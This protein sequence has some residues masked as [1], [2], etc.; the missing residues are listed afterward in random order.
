[1]IIAILADPIRH[2]TWDI[3]SGVLPIASWVLVFLA[4]CGC[5]WLSLQEHARS[6]RPSDLIVAYL[7]ASALC[8]AI[9]VT[10]PPLRGKPLLPSVQLVVKV[11]LLCLECQ[12]KDA[13]LLD[14]YKLLPAEERSGLLSRAFFWWIHDILAQ[15]YHNTLANHELPPM[16]EALQSETLRP[17]AVRIWEQ[18]GSA[19]CLGH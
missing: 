17:D 8:D 10:L 12:S 6:V 19:P 9:L 7:L 13:I 1:M 3:R 5:D 11:A 14:E 15:G 16:D 2:Q 18:Q 4:A